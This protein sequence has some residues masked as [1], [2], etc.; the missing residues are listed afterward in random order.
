MVFDLMGFF[1]E[2]IYFQPEYSRF[3]RPDQFLNSLYDFHCKN[4]YV[5]YSFCR[6]LFGFT[7]FQQVEL[8]IAQ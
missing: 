3:P 2:S 1:V 7:V 6:V 5:H 8:Q 4:V